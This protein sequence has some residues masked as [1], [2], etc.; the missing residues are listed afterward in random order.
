MSSDHDIYGYAKAMI[1]NYGREAR[2]MAVLRADEVLTQ[3]NRDDHETWLRVIIAII[4]LQDS[5]AAPSH[6]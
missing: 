5:D 2:Q 3:G 1:G 6:P 4:E